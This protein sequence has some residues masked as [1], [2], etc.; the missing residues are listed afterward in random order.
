MMKS[1][2]STLYLLKH[3]FQ[4]YFLS[5]KSIPASVSATT[6]MQAIYSSD[7]PCFPGES[8]H[9]INQ[10]RRLIEAHICYTSPGKMAPTFRNNEIGT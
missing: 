8:L 4:K 3:C 5:L 9:S 2:N 10:G 1:D 7:N 6:D